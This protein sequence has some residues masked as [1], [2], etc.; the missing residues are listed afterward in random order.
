[1][2]NYHVALA[3]RSRSNTQ[4]LK[5][6]TSARYVFVVNVVSQGH[7]EMFGFDAEVC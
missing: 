6:T 5:T 1:M 2:L 3:S 7:S 4:K